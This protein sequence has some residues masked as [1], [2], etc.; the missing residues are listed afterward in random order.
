MGVLAA[1]DGRPGG[2]AKGVGHESIGELYASTSQKFSGL[3]HIGEV[4]GSHV[5][6]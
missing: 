3:W 2:A 4:G 6:G 1:Q 5:V